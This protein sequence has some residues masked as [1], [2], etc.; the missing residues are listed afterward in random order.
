MPGKPTARKAQSPSGQRM[1]RKANAGQPK[2]DRKPGR[3][4]APP[5]AVSHNWPD[6]GACPTRKGA[7]AGQV[8]LWRR[9]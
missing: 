7:D 5:P 6:T 4:L 2:G 8:G 3:W 9:R 1:T